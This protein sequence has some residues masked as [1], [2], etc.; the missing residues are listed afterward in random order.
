MNDKH[1]ENIMF[2]ISVKDLIQLVP[3]LFDG[4][5]AQPGL[6]LKHPHA[7]NGLNLCDGAAVLGEATWRAVGARNST[8]TVPS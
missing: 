3:Y 4:A 5:W 1:N 7:Q 6:Q 2:E 8:T